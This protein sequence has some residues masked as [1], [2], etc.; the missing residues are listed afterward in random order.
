MP[1]AKTASKKLPSKALVKSKSK[2]ASKAKA[3]PKS[4]SGDRKKPRFKPG[5]VALREIKRYQKSSDLLLPKA[6]F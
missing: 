4:A 6:P 2:S 3:G 1:K 5:T